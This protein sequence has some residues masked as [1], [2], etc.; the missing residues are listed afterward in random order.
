[1]TGA[2]RHVVLLRGV[3][4]GRSKRIGMA[5]LREVLQQLGYADVSTYL[6]SGNAVLTSPSP[7]AEVAARVED[8]LAGALG[9]RVRVVVRSGAE[10]AA[11]VAADP[12]REVAGDPRLHFVGFLSAAPDPERVRELDE[13]AYAP[14]VFRL[15]GRELHLWLPG[16]VQDSPL[17]RMD[18]ERPSA[19]R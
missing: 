12:L 9:V 6:Q 13:S 18:W 15:D 5:Q 14:D 10:L 16:G 7:A 8:G 4:V 2:A 19:S 3:N 11:V 17:S 1:M